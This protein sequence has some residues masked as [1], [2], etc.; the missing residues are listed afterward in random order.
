MEFVFPQYIISIKISE[1]IPN[2]ISE[3]GL[4]VSELTD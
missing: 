2:E 1:N 3:D 4:N